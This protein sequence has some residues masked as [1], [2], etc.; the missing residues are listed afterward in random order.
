MAIEVT[1]NQQ[2]HIGN[3]LIFMCRYS[4]NRQTSADMACSSALKALWEY[5]PESHRIKI[6]DEIR[7]EADLDSFGSL[8]KD[9][10]EWES[11]DD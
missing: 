10:L 2:N 6:I 9:F 1:T 7:S 8:W 5:V 3:A 11:K 4:Y